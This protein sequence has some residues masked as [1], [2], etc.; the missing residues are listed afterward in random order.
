MSEPALLAM[1][2]ANASLVTLIGD[3][4]SPG[5]APQGTGRPAVTYTLVDDVP[6]PA[7]IL[8]TGVTRARWRLNIWASTYESGRQTRNALKTTYKRARGTYGG[9]VVQD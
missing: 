1:K 7:M 4:F 8:D 5:F 9:I 3:R 2:N 6:E